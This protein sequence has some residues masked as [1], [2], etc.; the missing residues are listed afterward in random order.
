MPEDRSSGPTPGQATTERVRGI[1][2]GIAADYDRLNAVL[3]LGIDE[4]WRRRVVR[5]AQVDSDSRVL[6]LCCGTGDLALTM[7]RRGRPAEVLATD[8]VPEMM[9]IAEQKVRRDPPPVPVRFAVADAQ[10]LPFDDEQFDVVTVGFGVRNLPDR[11]A[12]FREAY[13]VLK[14]G[15]RYLI[16]EMSRPPFVPFRV[17]YHWYLRHVVPWVG[18]A[19]SGDKK[20]YRY[21]SDSILEFPTQMAL[22]AELHAAGFET[23][24]YRNLTGG[25]VAVHVGIR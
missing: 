14:P 8:F 12:N 22:S 6:D 19:V 16:L 9:E 1:F 17:A 18:G 23:V 13:R 3:S 5:M 24:R 11:A 25:I 7:A 20:A 21:L 2:S 10:S 4:L 15:G